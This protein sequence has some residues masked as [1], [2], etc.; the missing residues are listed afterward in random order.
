MQIQCL[1]CKMIGVYFI[2]TAKRASN[3][4]ATTSALIMYFVTHTVLRHITIIKGYGCKMNEF[5]S[6]NNSKYF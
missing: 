1:W 5:L 3:F 2:I 6:M 4:Y